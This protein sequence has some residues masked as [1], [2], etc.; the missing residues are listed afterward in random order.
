MRE[1]LRTDREEDEEGE[2][3]GGIRQTARDDAGAAAPTAARSARD[4]RYSSP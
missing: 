2:G 1:Q 4:A 3:E